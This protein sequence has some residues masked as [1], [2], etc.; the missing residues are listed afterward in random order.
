MARFIGLPDIPRSENAWQ[1][2]ILEGLKQNVELLTGGRQESDRAS[3]A[4]TKGDI[5]LSP[6]PPLGFSAVS[7]RGDGFTI[8]GERVAGLDDYGKL[9]ADVQKLAEDV[10][11]LH[12]YVTILVQQLKR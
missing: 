9:I 10:A 11:I 12:R 7:A 1:T 2:Q 3:E 5:S 4:I 8:N 6:P